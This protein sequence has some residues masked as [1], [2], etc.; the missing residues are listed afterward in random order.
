M[1]PIRLLV[2]WT[3]VLVLSGCGGDSAESDQA[4]KTGPSL[5][6][7]VA[8]TGQVGDLVAQVGAGRVQVTSLMGPGVD[9]HLYKASAGDVDRLGSAKA[10][11][12]NGLHL[13]AKMAE[14]LERLGQR[15]PVFA[16]AD[17]IPAKKLVTA[18]GFSDVHDPHIWF[19]VSLW[20]HALTRVRD[21][22][23]E[24][25]SEHADLYRRNAAAY[26]K[27][28]GGLERWVK[29][30][31]ATIPPQQRVL[32]TAHDA[33][34]Y[35]GRAYGF[36]VR[37]LQGISTAT[38]AGTADV[39]DLAAFITERRI[40]ALFVES[41]VSPRA[42]AAVQ[43]AVRSRGHEVVIGGELFSDAMGDAGT[44]AGTYLGMFRHN[45]NTLVK[46]LIIGATDEH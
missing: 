10:I 36:E 39:Q 13:E 37:G 15:Q 18:E 9:P 16:V 28:L 35:F 24:I 30:A 21:A 12:Y 40:P 3:L 45:V 34:E 5:L 6:K 31:V 23:I 25:D 38:E 8:T 17:G 33:F 14:V 42:I 32:V 27:E 26:S 41:S 29:N 20:Q 19:D 4:S 43:A 44:P 46:S 2:F 11:F 1:R 22:L 7:V